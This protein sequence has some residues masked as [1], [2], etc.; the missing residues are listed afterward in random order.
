MTVPQKT[1]WEID[2]HTRAKH[3]ILRRYLGA[4]F[5]ILSRHHGRILYIDG[6]SGPGRYKG[7]EPGSPLVA[8]TTALS[9][10]KTLRGKLVFLFIDERPDRIAQLEQELAV[11]SLP[12]HFSAKAETG[13][14]HEKLTSIL[15]DLEAQSLQIAP[16]FAF[17]DPFGFKGV[18]FSLVERLLKHPRTEV[19][20]TFMVDSIN[21]FIEHPNDQVVQHIIDAF[22]TP[23]VL[24]TARGPGDRVETLRMLYQRQLEQVAKFV[25]YFEMRDAKN[26]TIYYLFFATN[27]PLGHVKMKEAF[28]K[29]D[30]ER[31]FRFSDATNPNQ[32]VMFEMDPSPTLAEILLQAYVSQTISVEQIQCFVE[33]RTPFLATHMR[34]AMKLLES[35]GQIT[36]KPLKRDGK[37]R[38]ASTFPK[39]V[40]ITFP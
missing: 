36:V 24:G 21:R 33:E 40:I 18:P 16:T 25:R 37:K 26:R 14:F 20:I 9:S 22:G 39:D 12:S 30:A 29:V 35:K 27:H 10:H 1:I 17:I 6:F 28:W 38:R 4:W 8:L 32:L 7:G 19:F 34:S 2:S 13:V 3:E 11:L 15:D 31:G 5:P 23:D